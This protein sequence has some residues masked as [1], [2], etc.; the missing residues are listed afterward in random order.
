[1]RQSNVRDLLFR[2]NIGVAK[3]V[4]RVRYR[5]NLRK[6]INIIPF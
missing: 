6:L 1:M 3:I 2:R 4:E 5:H